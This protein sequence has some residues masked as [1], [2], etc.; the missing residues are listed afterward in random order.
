MTSRMP[1]LSR[2][3]APNGGHE[4]SAR[5]TLEAFLDETVDGAVRHLLGG[6][7]LYPAR[8]PARKYPTETAFLDALSGADPTIRMDDNTLSSLAEKLADWSKGL[9]D[10]LRACFRLEAPGDD[11]EVTS[12]IQTPGSE[13][14]RLHFLQAT[15]DKSLQIPAEEVWKA[16]A[17][18]VNFLQRTFE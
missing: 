15:D 6:T 13:L 4:P 12:G 1:P 17:G 8:T 7:K 14:W 3:E 5:G 9:G 16:N 10:A 18:V 11:G 2:A